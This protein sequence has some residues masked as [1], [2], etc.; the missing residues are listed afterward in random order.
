M[1]R[2]QRPT[3]AVTPVPLTGDDVAEIVFTSGTT[4]EP[5]GVVITHRNLAASL[6]PVED[7]LAP[8]LKY[9]H[10]FAPLRFLNLLPMSHL[11]GQALGLFLPPIIP[12]SAVFVS[13]VS[14]QEVVRQIRARRICTVVAV[15]KILEVL[16]DFVIHRFP[17]AAGASHAINPWPLRLW[18]FRRVHRM[19]GWKFCS[20]FVG[21]APLPS[22]SRAVLG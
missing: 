11:F 5:K 21:G 10:P 1:E 14:A 12:A 20:F 22:E 17:E 16:R 2:A 15:P 3:P 18:R 6:R 9:V 7:Q 8:Y 4:A 13:S 19:F